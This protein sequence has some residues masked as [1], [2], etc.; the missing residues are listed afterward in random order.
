MFYLGAM[1][2]DQHQTWAIS[3]EKKALKRFVF[4]DM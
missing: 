1:A 4:S 2:I 3:Q